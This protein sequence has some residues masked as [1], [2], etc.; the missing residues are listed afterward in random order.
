MLCAPYLY[1]FAQFDDKISDKA[2]DLGKQL[3]GVISDNMRNILSYNMS[4]NPELYNSKEKT[5]NEFITDLAYNYLVNRYELDMYHT[6]EAY[7]KSRDNSIVEATTSASVGIGFLEYLKTKLFQE[8][9]IW[10][11]IDAV[12]ITDG[13]NSVKDATKKDSI[14]QESAVRKEIAAKYKAYRENLECS[15]LRALAPMSSRKS[16]EIDKKGM[17][18]HVIETEHPQEIIY[19]KILNGLPKNKAVSEVQGSD[20][21]SYIKLV[22][23]YNIRH[24]YFGVL[25][26]RPIIVVHCFDNKVAIYRKWWKPNSLV[27][28][29]VSYSGFSDS[30]YNN[31]E[32]TTKL[33]IAD[34]AKSLK[35]Y[36]SK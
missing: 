4:Q 13:I 25:P 23:T 3:R 36:L 22:L 9:K 6:I 29:E 16:V 24:Q 14:L 34:L 15:K 18:A 35:K 12:V 21:H 8:M 30:P 32:E 26:V 11:D 20:D 19:S 28:D 27:M 1:S 17:F 2:N 5:Q 31:L 33:A 10:A 7:A